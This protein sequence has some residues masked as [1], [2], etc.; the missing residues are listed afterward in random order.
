MSW[1]SEVAQESMAK[2]VSLAIKKESELVQTYHHYSER[3]KKSYLEALKVA[4]QIVKN[5]ISY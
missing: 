5:S 1:M 2:S 3:G 4:E